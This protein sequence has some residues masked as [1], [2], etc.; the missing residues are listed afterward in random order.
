MSC[1]CSICARGDNAKA[2]RNVLISYREHSHRVFFS[3]AKIYFLLDL[4]L[5]LFSNG[6]GIK[7]LG[8]LFFNLILKGPFV[9]EK[10]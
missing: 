4:D 8:L 7:D 2:V 5:Y 1:F 9:E 6:F 3:Y 10:N